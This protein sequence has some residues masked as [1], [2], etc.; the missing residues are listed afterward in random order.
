MGVPNHC[1]YFREL[2][3]RALNG[4]PDLDRIGQARTE[5]AGCSSCLQILDTEI[6]FKM[7]ISQVCREPAPA[8]LQIRIA[9]SLRRVVLDDLEIQDF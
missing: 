8:S 2:V 4:R 1:D 7:T 6:R 5:L 9:E 3:T